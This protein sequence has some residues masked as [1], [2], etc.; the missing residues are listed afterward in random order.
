[1]SSLTRPILH[2]G[3]AIANGVT[4]QRRL[5]KIFFTEVYSLS[6]GRYLYVLTKVRPDAIVGRREK[7]SVI[8]VTANDEEYPCVIASEHTREKVIAV[9]ESLTSLRGLDSVAGMNDLKRLLINDVINPLL[10]PEKYK[11]FRLSIPNGI[12]LYGPPGCG[13][14]FIVKKLAEELSYNMFQLNPSS[15]ATPYVHGA[16]S[17]I[18]KVFEMARMGAP[19]IVFIDEI[20]GLIPKREELGPHADIKKEEI[21]EFLLQLNNAGDSKILV[22]GAT[23]R[24]QIIDTAILRS[25]RMDKRIFVPPPDF[26]ARKEMFHLCLMGRPYDQAMDFEKLARMTENFVGSDI[27][28]IVTE[29]AREAV[30]H[31][32]AQIDEDL[33]LRVIARMTP[34]V[35]QEEIESY[36]QFTNIERL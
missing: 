19:A 31:D 8:T 34:S 10:N 3:F 20:E 6:D 16:V 1:M 7:H 9:T 36:G 14:T 29:A 30:T 32:K 17:N 18:A 4:V 22:V 23:N 27:E 26:E 11:K 15:V 25:G 21:N 35:S 13:K 12:L 2:N 28:L 33:I 24:P 5:E